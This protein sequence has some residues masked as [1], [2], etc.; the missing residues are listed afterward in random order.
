MPFRK[1][2]EVLKAAHDNEQD[3]AEKDK[4]AKALALHKEV[5]DGPDTEDASDAKGDAKGSKTASKTAANTGTD[6]SGVSGSPG[7][8]VTVTITNTHTDHNPAETRT[9]HN[10]A[11]T[12]D[13]GITGGSGE[14]AGNEADTG[15]GGSGD[16]VDPSDGDT[17]DK[18]DGDA[19]KAPAKKKKMNLHKMPMKDL[20]KHVKSMSGSEE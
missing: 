16:T 2:G 1:M 10:P 3:P 6:A 18:A 4:L 11:K 7:G 17:A 8:A 19:E 14:G 15:A 12:G 5:A 20:E 9:D 13:S